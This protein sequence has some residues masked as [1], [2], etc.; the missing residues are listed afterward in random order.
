[1]SNLKMRFSAVGDMVIQRRIPSDNIYFRQ[2]SEYISQ[3]DGRFANLETLLHRG[4]FWCNQFYGG[5]YHRADPESIDDVKGYGINLI[6]FANNHSFDYSYGGL[7]ATYDVI[8]KSGVVQAGV[9]HNL[10]EAA[11]PS[12]LETSVGRIALISA[13]STMVNHAAMAGRQSRRIQGRPGVNGL[14][15]D[16]KLIVTKDQMAAIREFAKASHINASKEI[17]ISEGYSLPA[18]PGTFEMKGLKFVE[19]PENCL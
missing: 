15:I 11:A 8:Q 12:Y 4:E 7:L 14:R 3:C 17:S 2:I 9:G 10:D 16:E 5:S 18:D 6:S 1:M 19:G 13:V